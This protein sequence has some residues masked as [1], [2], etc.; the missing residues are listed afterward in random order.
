MKM[1]K[2]NFSEFYIQ[3]LKSK[4]SIIEKKRK[5]SVRLFLLVILSFTLLLLMMFQRFIHSYFALSFVIIPVIMIGALSFHLIFKKYRKTYKE[6]IIPLIFNQIFDHFDYWPNK[7]LAESDYISTLL[8]QEKFN[9]YIGDDLVVGTFNGQD[10]QMSELTVKQVTNH[11]KNKKSEK[12]V[13]RGIMIILKMRTP[14]HSETI[15][16]PD[17]AE[18]AFGFLGKMLQFKN[19]CNHEVVRLES[20]DFEKTFVVHSSDQI[21]ARKIL[22]PHVQERLLALTQ[23]SKIKFSLS[24]LPNQISI[25]FPKFQNQFEPPYFSSNEG[26]KSVREIVELFLFLEE[27]LLELDFK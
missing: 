19:R 9:Q 7:Y 20:I 17:I 12:I 21:D 14:Y 13:F 6:K 2:A 8:Y 27:L 5:E 18:R 22:T 11:G 10:I 4:F 24:L 15:I 23:K 1:N 26:S 3:N 25:A 16:G